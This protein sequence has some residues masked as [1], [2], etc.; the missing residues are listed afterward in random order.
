[1]DTHVKA[2]LAYCLDSRPSR[3][4]P[5]KWYVRNHGLGGFANTRDRRD[6]NAKFE[7]IG[8]DVFVVATKP[9][10]AGEEVFVYYKCR[11]LIQ[12]AK[13]RRR[14]LAK[15][16]EAAKALAALLQ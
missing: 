9:I 2:N 13:A 7:T 11:K 10:A 3:E 5:L 12:A 15:R 16:R 4:F 8:E 14:E 6:C 1:L